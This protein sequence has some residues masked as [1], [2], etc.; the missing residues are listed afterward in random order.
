MANLVLILN[1]VILVKENG[2]CPYKH[3]THCNGI[4][5]YFK[6]NSNGELKYIQSGMAIDSDGVMIRVLL[7]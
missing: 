2:L 7:N 6:L 4:W 5:K 3:L 1:N